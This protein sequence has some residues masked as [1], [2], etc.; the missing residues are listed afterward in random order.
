MQP[1]IDRA[2]VVEAGRANRRSW[3]LV[4]QAAVVAPC[5]AGGASRAPSDED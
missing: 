4:S 1:C 3:W 5:T 2:H